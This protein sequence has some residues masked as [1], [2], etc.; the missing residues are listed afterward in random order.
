M[1]VASR[2]NIRM[3]PICLDPD[4]QGRLLKVQ[5]I[6][7]TGFHMPLRLFVSNAFTGSCSAWPG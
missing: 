3:S 6:S 5:E 1:G 4:S 2:L 7:Q